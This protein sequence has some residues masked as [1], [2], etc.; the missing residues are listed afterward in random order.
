M[1]RLI[2]TVGLSR[3]DWL[4]ARRQ[5]ITGTDAGAITGMNPYVSAFQVYQDKHSDDVQETDNEA[6]R[7]GRDLEEYVA[8]RFTEA[9]GLKVHRAN[10]IFQNE[11]HPV[12]LADFDRLIVGQK[13][14][15]ECKTVSPYSAGKWKDGAIPLHYQMQV[16]HYLAVSGFDCWYIAAII[17]GREFIIRKIERDEELIQYLITIE[18][19]FWNEHVLAHVMPEPDGSSS[20]SEEIAKLYCKSDNAKAVKLMGCNSLLDRRQ[21]LAALI[22]TVSSCMST[23]PTKRQPSSR[24]S[25][26]KCRTQPTPPPNSTGCRGYPATPPAW[27]PSG[28]RQNSPPSIPSTARPPAAVGSP[29]PGRPDIR[30]NVP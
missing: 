27:M 28:S 13:A 14:G 8:S 20:C 1:K 18:E 12:M 15:L 3:A 4:R 22:D 17:F 6:M 7:Q 16:Q 29:S 24:R 19:R 5:G 23:V 10:A 21:E 25:N 26:W 9:T 2:S 30:R 11:E